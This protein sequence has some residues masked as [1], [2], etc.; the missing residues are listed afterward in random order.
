VKNQAIFFETALG[1]V[2]CL[3]GL[4][5]AYG[6]VDISAEAGYGG[7]GP[8]FLPWVVAVV[9]FVCG[10]GLIWQ[11]KGKGYADRE[12]PEGAASGDWLSFAW[13]SAGILSNA[14]LINRL[15]FVLSCALCFVLAVRGFHRGQGRLDLSA[16]AWLRDAAI[17]LSISA[18]VYWMFGQLLGIQLPG[19]TAT[20]WL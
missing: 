9:L 14:L 2:F 7:V 20:G 11:G 5:L 8:N 10:L 4:S 15:G 12:A 18:P 6:A 3:I 1:A 19:L 13:V 16:K 17:G